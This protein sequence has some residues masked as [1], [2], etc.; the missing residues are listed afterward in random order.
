MDATQHRV[1]DIVGAVIFIIAVEAT[2]YG[3]DAGRTQVS[4]GA[5]I[6]VATG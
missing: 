1:A 5:Y 2:T 4:G 3:A 6:I